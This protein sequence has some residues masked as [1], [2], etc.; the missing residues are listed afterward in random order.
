MNKSY[1]LLLIAFFIGFSITGLEIS[2]ARLLAP[3]FGTSVLIWTNI[4]GV[5][6]TALAIGYYIGGRLSEVTTNLYV[7]LRII[8]I[9]GLL[10]FATP[11]A[12]KFVSDLFQSNVAIGSLIVSIV[13]FGLPIMLLGIS[14]PFLVKV[15][16]TQSEHIGFNSGKIFAVSTIGSIIGTFAPTFVFIPYLGTKNTIFI[17]SVALVA[18][19]ILG[20]KGY[21]SKILLG[22]I[23]V[24]L[25]VSVNK[26][27]PVRSSDGV[28]DEYESIYQFIQV[29][30]GRSDLRY[31][32]VDEGKGAQ[33]IYDPKRVIGTTYYDLIASVPVIQ[34]KPKI[35]VLIVGLAG[36]TIATKMK[37]EFGDRVELEAVEID[38]TMTEVANKYFDLS[39][40]KIKTFHADGRVFLS[41]TKSEYD[42]IVVD[43][44]Q[45]ESHIPWT[46]TTKE[47]W[48][49]VNDRLLPE[50]I[51]AL[52]V[53]A[54]NV[55]SPLLRAIS[56]T[57]ASS[58]INAY[59]GKSGDFGTNYL[60]LASRD[61]IQFKDYSDFI[62]YKFKWQKQFSLNSIVYDSKEKILTDDK[63]PVEFLSE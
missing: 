30:E 7:L 13:L 53:N 46:F 28:I 35:K 5:V 59:I 6:M 12:V 51:V 4:I 40:I 56:N 54:R 58:F 41:N 23:L 45:N 48:N 61:Q 49:L 9:A 2:A 10:S 57:I 34:Q 38:P 19:G 18:M 3:F 44:Y 22:V 26:S 55:A 32:T 42:L 15:A 31:I 29:H 47:F 16:S 20:F 39:A 24:L 63:A 17:F 25:S 11:F 33:S 27:L 43:A 50:G 8:F 36:G 52:N 1:K 14:S 21:L 37:A 60:I 62:N